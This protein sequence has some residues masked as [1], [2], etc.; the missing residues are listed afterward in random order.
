MKK[1]IFRPCC[2]MRRRTF[3]TQ[4]GNGAPFLESNLVY[5]LFFAESDPILYEHADIGIHVQKNNPWFREEN[6]RSAHAW[7]GGIVG[8]RATKITGEWVRAIK[9]DLKGRAWPM[10]LWGSMF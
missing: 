1:I 10:N 9:E 6:I 5:V 7:M 3:V 2:F 4:P 8:P